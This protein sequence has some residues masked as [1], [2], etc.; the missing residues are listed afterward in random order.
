MYSGFHKVPSITNLS[1]TINGTKNLGDFLISSEPINT[2]IEVNSQPISVK[3]KNLAAR[4]SRKV[5]NFYSFNLIFVQDRVD[6]DR[7][8]RFSF[9]RWRDAKKAVK[10]ADKAVMNT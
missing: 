4:R 7:T 10:S 1:N 3:E 8:T 6:I 2:R 9:K 5:C